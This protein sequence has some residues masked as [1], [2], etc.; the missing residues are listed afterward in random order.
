[1]KKLITIIALLSLTVGCSSTG[2]GSKDKNIA[3]G[4][5]IKTE[6]LE[7]ISKVRSF[8]FSGWQSLTNNFLILSSSQEKHLIEL[9]NYCQEL[10][11]TSAIIVDKGGDS[12]LN[13]RFD[14]ISAVDRHK[15][16]CFIKSIYPVTKEQSRAILAIG[17]GKTEE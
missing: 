7:S 8:R 1:M 16:K 15:V 12:S 2:M 17:S 5:Y 14:S 13:V 4:E 6:N 10:M 11:F 3:Y 9:N